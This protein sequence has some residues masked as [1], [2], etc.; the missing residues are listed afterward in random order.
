MFQFYADKNNLTVRQKETVT[1]GSV[2]V[3][4]AR[5]EFSPDWEDLER[6]AV[7]RGGGEPVSVRL[8]GSGVCQ[9][10]WEVLARSG[11]HLYAGVWGGREGEV[12]LPTV[13]ADCGF[14]LTGVTHGAEAQP[15]TPDL[16]RQELAA[17]GDTLEYTWDGALGLYAGKKLLSAIPLS[18]GGGGGPS[19]GVG[20]GLKVEDGRLAVD[21][22]EDFDGDNTLPI[23]AAAVQTTVGNI[24]KLLGTI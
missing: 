23:T 13:W 22:A 17:K 8:D 15:P 2:N 12:L 4:E 5:F 3:C 14:I 7:F 19:Y 1:S 21:A 16:W 11:V 18:G 24:E 20:H 6:T 10:P 9:I